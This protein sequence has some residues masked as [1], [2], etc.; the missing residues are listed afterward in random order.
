ML[1]LIQKDVS[2]M[3][4][5]TVHLHYWD[6]HMT[7][8]KSFSGGSMKSMCYV[9]HSDLCEDIGSCSCFTCSQVLTWSPSQLLLEFTDI[10]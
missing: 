4:T 8:D 9:L 7:P 6:L 2:R 3:P 1:P 10:T 5:K